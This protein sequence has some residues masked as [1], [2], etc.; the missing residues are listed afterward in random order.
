L[1][2][3]FLVSLLVFLFGAARSQPWHLIWPA[4]LAG[5]STQRWAWPMVI[6]LS[7]LMLVTQIWVEWGTPGLTLLF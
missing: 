7:A 5:L 4:S 1:D 2:T 3:G 6:L